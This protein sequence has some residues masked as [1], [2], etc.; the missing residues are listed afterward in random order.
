MIQHSLG[1]VTDL[2]TYENGQVT[3]AIIK[4]IF[5]S[6]RFGVYYYSK[7]YAMLANKL[8]LPYPCCLKCDE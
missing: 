2:Q 6:L 8:S 5:K 7:I 1:G 3:E 4:S